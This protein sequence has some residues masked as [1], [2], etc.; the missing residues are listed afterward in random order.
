MKLS[1]CSPDGSDVL[2]F[3]THEHHDHYEGTPQLL[4]RFPK[5]MMLVHEG[6]Q[7]R[8]FDIQG[9][10]GKLWPLAAPA[11]THEDAS[12]A[13]LGPCIRIGEPG[14]PS[15]FLH[16]ACG[17]GHTSSHT[18]LFLPSPHEVLLAGDHVVGYGSAVLDPESG[19]IAEYLATTQYLIDLSPRIAL[20]AHGRPLLQPI[21]VLRHYYKH[22]LAREEAILAAVHQLASHGSASAPVTVTMAGIVAVVYATTPKE[23]W[24]AAQRN[25]RLHVLKLMEEG[26]ID[27]GAAVCLDVVKI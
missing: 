6:I 25:V 14:T 22:R 16:L 9:A 3:L 27:A 7:Q 2:V 11:S 10:P 5:A 23:L 20:P 15:S 21:P 1:R 8:L 18:C 17:K 26:R 4:Q 13:E 19:S 24:P 12:R